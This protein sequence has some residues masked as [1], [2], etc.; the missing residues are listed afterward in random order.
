[1]LLTTILQE[2]ELEIDINVSKEDLLILSR[3]FTFFLSQCFLFCHLFLTLKRL[4]GG[5]G[6]S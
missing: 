3:Y 1:M 2:R 5:G 6:V 4:E